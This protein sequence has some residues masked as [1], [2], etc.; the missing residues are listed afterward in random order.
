MFLFGTGA[1]NMFKPAQREKWDEMVVKI[2]V[3][4]M[5]GGTADPI[6]FHGTTQA[7]AQAIVADGFDPATSYVAIHHPDGSHAGLKPCVYWTTHLETAINSAW[8]HAGSETGFAVIFAAR[9]SDLKTSGTLAPELNAWSIDT[10]E[11]PDR[12]PAT[13][14][15][16]LQKFDAIA[17]L[18]CSHVPNLKLY[19]A[20]E[21][22]A[23]PDRAYLTAKANV[24]RQPSQEDVE[25]RKVEEAAIPAFR[26]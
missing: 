14:E 10:D 7:A 2:R 24:C 15:D 13:W 20:T 12:Y 5:L 26:R 6:L 25:R 11:D 19:A 17:V 21:P 3:Q 4:Q 16:S 8:R 22:E 9:L 1:E 23:R 18:D